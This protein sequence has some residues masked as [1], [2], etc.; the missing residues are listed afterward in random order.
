[1]KNFA[2]KTFKV[3]TTLHL[4]IVLNFIYSQDTI[5]FK[6]GSIK[7]GRVLGLDK[8]FNILEFQNS[9]GKILIS[10][11]ELKSF[12]K[13]QPE[14]KW[15]IGETITYSKSE[16]H[17]VKRFSNNRKYLKYEPRKYSLGLNFTSLFNQSLF[18]DFD[19]FNR[20]YST[21]PYLECFFQMEINEGIALRFPTRI[22]INPLNETILN[23]QWYYNFYELYSRELI[24]D[25]GIEPIFYF[26]K[27]PFKVKWF[28]AP[29]ISATLG[30]PVAYSLDYNLDIE[31]YEPLKNKLGFRI[32]VLSG[33]Q[34]WLNSRFQFEASFG[35][36]VTNNYWLPNYDSY[37]PRRKGYLGRNLRTALIYRL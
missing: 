12:T 30:K 22:G 35:Y 37:N 32:G 15:N 5:E 1:M 23:S 17:Y 2:I 18:Y 3:L 24:F 25:I 4:C 31:K 33:F 21:N 34:Y 9:N 13:H 27:T 7:Y 16:S 6:D 10:V 14:E 28:Y 19:F 29:S 11:S 36:F 26:N 8:K 20:T